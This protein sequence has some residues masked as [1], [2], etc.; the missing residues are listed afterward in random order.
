MI[1]IKSLEKFY[2]GKSVLNISSLQIHEGEIVGVVGNNGAGKTTMFSL[3]LDLIKATKGY[4][5]SKNMDV[6]KTENWKKYTAAFLDEGFLINFLTPD[7]YFEFAGKIHHMTSPE[8]KDFVAQFEEIFNGEIIG[9][10]KYIRDLSKGNMK[11][12]G[13]VS[14]LIGQ[15][16]LVLLDEPFA[17]LDPSTQLR[18][19][20]ILKNHAEKRTFLISSH[21]LNHIMDV[22]TRIVILEKGEVIRDV[23]RAETSLD[24]LLKYF[25]P[26]EVV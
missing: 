3:I 1:E 25:T 19:K 8:I 7:E 11:K 4:V 22:C 12:V 20:S 9:K 2:A 17:N 5:L 21:D 16:E 18:V 14:A 26:E 13:I 15:P 10:K 6:S 24:E 23:S